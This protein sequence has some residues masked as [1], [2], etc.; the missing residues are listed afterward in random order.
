MSGLQSE[1]S[2]AIEVKSLRDDV[3]TLLKHRAECDV[4]HEQHTAHSRRHDDATRNLTESNMLLARSI[5]DMNITLS[6]VVKI[7]D[8]ENDAP[9]IKIIRNART[10]WSVNKMLWAGLIGLTTGITAIIVLYK[11]IVGL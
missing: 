6:K 7:L 4:L 2:M 10:A 1:R 3:D 5:T 9:E 8:V 11:V